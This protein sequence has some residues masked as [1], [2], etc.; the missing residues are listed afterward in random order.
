MW[1]RTTSVF[2]ICKTYKLP[3]P[4]KKGLKSTS[5]FSQTLCDSKLRCPCKLLSYLLLRNHLSFASLYSANNK[6]KAMTWGGFPQKPHRCLQV[7][8]LLFCKFIFSMEVSFFCKFMFFCFA[9][10]NYFLCKFTFFCFVSLYCFYLQ[11]YILLFCNFI[12]FCFSS[13]YSFA[14]LHSANSKS[15]AMTWGGF[16]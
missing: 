9:I 7:Y 12:L 8:I 15:K 4:P 11:A 14:D 16:P 3:T 13:F 5:E 10:L 2:S 6:S 1:N